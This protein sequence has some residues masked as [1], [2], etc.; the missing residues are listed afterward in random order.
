MDRRRAGEPLLGNTYWPGFVQ[1]IKLDLFLFGP[2]FVF[3]QEICKLITMDLVMSILSILFVDFF[4]GLWV[5]YCNRWWC[6]NLE[7]YFVRK[8]KMSN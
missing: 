3:M 5:R 2:F 7:V 6:W 8:K 1:T 4:R